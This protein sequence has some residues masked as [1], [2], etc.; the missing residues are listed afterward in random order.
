MNQSTGGNVSNSITHEMIEA[1]TAQVTA[2]VVAA[3]SAQ[4]A[5]DVDGP[6]DP[7]P[8]VVAN[9]DPRIAAIRAITLPV[10][11]RLRWVSVS[12]RADYSKMQVNISHRDKRYTP[13]AW[14][15][16]LH[17]APIDLDDP[18]HLDDVRAACDLA[19]D[20]DQ[21]I[22]GLIDRLLAGPA[23]AVAEPWDLFAQAA[24]HTLDRGAGLTLNGGR[25]E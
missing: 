8:V 17:A 24:N 20:L 16:Q 2:A 11:R 22:G 6:A 13:A 3:V 21:K 9:E 15:R 19:A 5:A 18:A 25:H 7:A 10:T 1:I 12:Y 14:G 4:V 23:G